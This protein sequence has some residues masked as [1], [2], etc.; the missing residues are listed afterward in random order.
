MQLEPIQSPS[1][2]LKS[3]IGV[4][5]SRSEVTDCSSMNHNIILCIC[6]TPCKLDRMVW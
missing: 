1:N 3:N 4:Y 5:L 2:A 6:Y